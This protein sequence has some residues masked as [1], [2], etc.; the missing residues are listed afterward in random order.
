[1][2]DPTKPTGEEL[3]IAPM[4]ISLF[5]IL[6]GVLS[7]GISIWCGNG[8]GAGYAL[9][10]LFVGLV[11]SAFGFWVGEN[12]RWEHAG[13]VF[14]TVLLL[15]SASL[16]LL[17]PPGIYLQQGAIATYPWWTFIK[18]VA[19]LTGC[20]CWFVDGQH[21][22]WLYRTTIAF[23]LASICWVII[24]SPL[25]AI[26][27]VQ[28]F[29]K[30]TEVLIGGG[31]PYTAAM[32]N[33]YGAETRLYAPSLINGDRLNFGFPYPLVTLVLGF[34]GQIILGDYRFLFALLFA[35]GLLLFGNCSGKARLASTC[36]LLNPRLEFF[37]EQGWTDSLTP[38]ILGLALGALSISSR[39]SDILLALWIGSKPYLIPFAVLRMPQRWE[40]R[41]MK[42]V[43]LLWGGVVILYTIPLF[44]SPKA[45]LWS[46]FQIQFVQ[47][48]R[49][50]SLSFLFTPVPALIGAFLVW[51]TGLIA[52]LRRP[53]LLFSD[54]DRRLLLLGWL[55]FAFFAFNKQAFANYYFSLLT[56]LAF[57]S[58]MP[59]N[60]KPKCK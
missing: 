60:N 9:H 52:I 59:F 34:A 1:M 37:F 11:C 26:D 41:D 54:P 24:N 47:P 6:S 14:A 28:F 58:V 23:T 45:Y 50:D 38:G 51:L 15:G 22:K 48:V 12:K 55:L 4:K 56:I 25:P 5:W 10:W 31:D 7:I 2:S 8:S 42:N 13:K 43:Y 27:V 46:A 40:R 33:I 19:L 32:P 16:T 39:A 36:I 57:A 44:I 49:T 3:K 29:R 35:A 21:A 17:Q 20:A 18:T 30:S 53:V